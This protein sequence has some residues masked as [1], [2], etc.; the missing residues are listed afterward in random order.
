MLIEKQQSRNLQLQDTVTLPINTATLSVF[1]I[2]ISMWYHGM[3]ESC[4][5]HGAGQVMVSSQVGWLITS[6]VRGGLFFPG[7][8]HQ[9]SQQG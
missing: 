7:F 6:W 9:N 5:L 4:F 1:I 8:M 3:K 2:H